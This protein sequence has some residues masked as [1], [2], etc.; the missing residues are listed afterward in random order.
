M[1]SI[2]GTTPIIM[3]ITAKHIIVSSNSPFVKYS[4]TFLCSPLP[5]L[6][7]MKGI[8]PWVKQVQK[9]SPM[10]NSAFAKPTPANWLVPKCPTIILS[11]NCTT[12]C[13]AWVIITGKASERLRL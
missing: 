2:K 10:E 8:T 5:K 3:A 4:D 11:A 12:I 9:T 7:P 6:C 13:P 1:W